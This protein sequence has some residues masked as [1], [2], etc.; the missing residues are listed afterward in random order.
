MAFA[1][2]HHGARAIGGIWCSARELRTEGGA[3]L[4]YRSK[5]LLSWEY[6]HVL[7]GR[8]QNGEHPFDLYNPWECWECPEFFP[9]GVKHVLIYSTGGKAFWQSGVFD[10]ETL[11]FLPEQ[12]GLMDYGSLYAPKTQLDK[13]GN[14]ILWGWIQ[15]SR[16]LEQYKA[17]G[18]AGLMSLPRVL[19]LDS[20]GRLKSKVA[21]EVSALRGRE[22]TLDHTADEEKNQS[23]IKAMRIEGCCG[24]ILC[25]VKRTAEPF[26][27]VLSAS[28]ANSV[29]WLTLKY[30]PHHLDQILI[31]AHPIPIALGDSENLE[32]HFYIDGS[33]IELFVNSQVTCTRRFYYSGK[34]P[35]DL[36]MN[37]T[38]KTANI[39]SLSVWQLSP[40]SSNRLTT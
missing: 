1:I 14:R 26:E 25:R 23:Q 36:C 35:Q 29:P 6:V 15:E 8:N 37:W 34:N 30:D 18:W 4:L 3:V 32:F 19:S 33:V 13:S 39:V 24:K 21:E 20:N 38:G 12:A 7:A 17:A 11:R 22:Q 9:L 5:D 16:P 10:P 27:L 31:D 28:A 2:L 40:I